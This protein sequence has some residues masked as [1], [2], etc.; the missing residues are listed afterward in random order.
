MN[1]KDNIIATVNRKMTTTEERYKAALNEIRAK[2]E[3]LKQHLLGRV[4][5]A[6]SKEYVESVLSKYRKSFT[7]NC[8]EQL[9]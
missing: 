5:E 2:D 8:E 9:K 7:E 3:F 4:E 1:E 6:E